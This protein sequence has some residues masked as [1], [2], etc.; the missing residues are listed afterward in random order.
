MVRQS[1]AQ[2]DGTSPTGAP[3][4]LRRPK[5]PVSFIS[6]LSGRKGFNTEW[7]PSKAA[8]KASA[9]NQKLKRNITIDLS[10]R[11]KAIRQL[12][13]KQS[14]LANSLSQKHLV[15]TISLDLISRSLAGQGL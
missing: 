1:K 7:M 9:P 5:N 15:K 13:L 4:L 3:P 14:N 10:L 11:T 6:N 2:L 8:K 12:G